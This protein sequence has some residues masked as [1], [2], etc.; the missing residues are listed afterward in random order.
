MLGP[1]VAATAGGLGLGGA[2]NLGK[3]HVLLKGTG[4]GTGG[5]V[6]AGSA[7]AADDAVRATTR[8]VDNV[9]TSEGTGLAVVDDVMEAANNT[10]FYLKREVEKLA[11]GAEPP[12]TAMAGD[13]PKTGSAYDY[14]KEKAARQ[15]GLN[16][17]G[18]SSTP[19]VPVPSTRASDIRF[20]QDSIR[21]TFRD[22]GSVEELIK[23]LKSGEIDPADV[24]AIRVFEKNGVTFSLDNRRL[25]AF[26]EAGVESIPTVKVDPT[27]P[28]IATEIA[29][30]MTTL[31]EG[32][33]I[34]VR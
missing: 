18:P 13:P 11:V 30:K 10:F 33:S 34:R 1:N 21:A 25:H 9:A 7:L 32:K 14:F 27:D 22:G 23:G 3:S 17:G 12:V 15:R 16:V 5:R 8:A 26:K 2:T 28:A 31:D 19:S 24:P 4:A 6:V 20:T 29:R